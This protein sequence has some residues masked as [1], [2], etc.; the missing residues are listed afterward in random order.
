[1]EAYTHGH[2]ADSEFCQLAQQVGSFCGCPAIEHHC[3]YCPQGGFAPDMYREDPKIVQLKQDLKVEP[4]CEMIESTQFQWNDDSSTCV[5][6]KLTAFLCG[7]SNGEFNYAGANTEAKRNVFE[8]TSRIAGVL[9]L[10]G[11]TAIQYD[12]LS[13]KRKRTHVYNRLVLVMSIFD[14][15]TAIGLLIGTAAMPSQN[16][17]GVPLEYP[18]SAGNVA[19]CKIQVRTDFLHLRHPNDSP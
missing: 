11:T 10:L 18:G 7:C 1:M 9:S 2:D 14:E 17:L 4:T 8:W 19:T 5:L 12:V 15:F 6:G 16:S 3:V 13:N